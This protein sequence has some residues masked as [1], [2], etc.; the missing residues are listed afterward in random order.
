M[1]WMAMQINHAQL[2][3]LIIALG[4][5]FE[6]FDLMIFNLLTSSLVEEFVGASDPTLKMLFAYIGYAIA[7]LFRPLGAFF[8]GCIGD[9]YGRKTALVSSMCLMSTATIALAFIPGVK[10]LGLASTLLFLLCRI[11]QGLAVGGE[12][13]TA[14]T[15]AYELNPKFRTFFGA[16]VI[17]S[18]HFGG[19]S[20]SFLASQFV[21]NI[22]IPFLIGGVL[23][24]FLLLFRSFMK[25]S[26]TPATTK[27]SE[28]ATKSLKNKKAILSALLVASTMV[29]VFYGSLIYLNERVHFDFGISRAEI[30]QANTFLLGLWIILPPF[31]GYIADKLAVSYLKL[32]RIGALGVF[33]STPLLGIALMSLSYTAL[34]SAQLLTHLFLMVFA[35]CTP[36]FF[37]DLFAKEAR[38]TAISTTYSVGSSFTSALAPVICH[39]SIVLFNTNFAICVPFMLAALGT[40]LILKKETLCNKM[41]LLNSTTSK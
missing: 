23:G 19:M 21:D 20:A 26:F 27:V 28:V 1:R 38:N 40:G 9:L 17:S 10:M 6:Y 34:L 12:Y 39:G 36:H 32:M 4:V 2:S 15:Y 22:R 16:C 33:F 13:G 29:L 8:F 24:F 11:T 25:E 3:F 31:F 18:T 14:M 5:S 7:F 30:F 35:L 37:G 41:T